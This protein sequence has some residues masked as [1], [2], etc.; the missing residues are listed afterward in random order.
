MPLRLP[1]EFINSLP[2]GLLSVRTIGNGI[3]LCLHKEEIYT[4]KIN[5]SGELIYN[6]VWSG[7]YLNVIHFNTTHYEQ[8]NC[9]VF[10][11][12]FYWDKENRKNTYCKIKVVS[13]EELNESHYLK[14]QF[15][16]TSHLNTYIWTLY[17]SNLGWQDWSK[18]CE[19]NITLGA[20]LDSIEEEIL[21]IYIGKYELEIRT[22]NIQYILQPTKYI[23]VVTKIKDNKYS[24]HEYY[25]E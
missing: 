22:Q 23:I 7:T 4:L 10:I 24:V 11:C 5:I 8:D 1:I 17:D 19:L 12:V 2:I 21:E 3:Y 15:G 25:D 18:Y 9:A 20:F 13:E 6:K 16:M 14:S